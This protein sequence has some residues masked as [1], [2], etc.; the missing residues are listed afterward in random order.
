MW[1]SDPSLLGRTSETVV[2]LP[3]V[4]HPLDRLDLNYISTLPL[5]LTSFYKHTKITTIQRELT[6]EKKT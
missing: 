1:G 6:D 4:G 2:T 5:L 3:F